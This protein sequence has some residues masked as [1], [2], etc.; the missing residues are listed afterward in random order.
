MSSHTDII[1]EALETQQHVCD[2][3]LVKITGI[4]PHQA[5]NSACRRL[6]DRKAVSRDRGICGVCG[7]ARIVNR[8]NTPTTE[9]TPNSTRQSHH[10]ESSNGTIEWL[11]NVRRNVIWHLNRIE[12]SSPQGEPFSKRIIRM[13]DEGSIPAPIACLIQTLNGFRNVACYEQHRLS[14]AQRQI[15]GLA[16]GE[17]ATWMKQ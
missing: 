15:V 8:L 4:H 6:T 16:Y 10:P 13:Q 12:R 14:D 11:D 1:S 3:C 2:G 7:H 17:V 5:V 9:F